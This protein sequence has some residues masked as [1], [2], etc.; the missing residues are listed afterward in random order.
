MRLAALLFAAM[1]LAQTPAPKS[2]T[3]EQLM[4][5]PFPSS[6]VASP[7]G[8][9]IAWV[10]NA[11]GVRNIWIAM[12]PDYA[13][14]KAIT[15]FKS[16]DGQEISSLAW[17]ADAGAIVFVRGTGPNRA[18]EIANA[19]SDPAGV[20]QAV[21]V[22]PSSGGEPR[23]LGEGSGPEVSKSGRVAWISKG[24]VWSAGAD[25]G[26][27]PEQLFK[28]RGTASSLRW[29][30]DGN[31]L[32]FVS[33]RGDHGF[34]GVYDVTAK[35]LRFLAAS[36]DSD[37][38]PAWSPDGKQIAFL[39]LPA[40]R[41]GSLF[42]P[43]RTGAPW[44][45]HIA[46]VSSGE[47]RQMFTAEA[48]RGSVFHAMTAPNQVLWAS[49]GH[50]VFP[51][52]R[53]GW[54][55]LYAVSVT[56][57]TAGPR[58]LTFGDF[59]VE[60]ARLTADGR[61]VL[62]SSNSDDIDR[63]H[64][65]RVPA[66]G[67]AVTPVTSGKG[68]EWS[69]VMTSDGKAVAFLRSDAR[70]P[71]R[72][73]VM[74]AF[75]SPRDLMPLE[76]PADAL[77]EPQPVVITAADGMKIRCQLFASSTTANEKRPA[78]LF[79]HGGSRRQMLLG[80]HYMPY[81]HATYAMNQWLASKGYIVLSVNYRSGT[82]YG[83]DFREATNFG[84]TGAAE[85]NDVMGAGLYLQSRADVDSARIGL[86]G[87]SYGGYLT[88][89]GLARASNL[90]AAGVDIHGVHDWNVVLRNFNPGYNALANP[91]AAKLAFESSP[92]AS[93]KTWKSPVLLI[94]GDDDRNVPFSESVTM[95]AALRK[96]GVEFEQLIFP[97][98]IH[99]FLRH[100]RWLEVFRAAGDFLDRQLK[101]S[102]K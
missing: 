56:G 101:A 75:G 22:V 14:P 64:L 93:V 21:W 62:F 83:L 31:Q 6:L 51:W 49:S 69:P 63:R 17:T 2:L 52:E 25:A 15:A 11:A 10:Q 78:V 44:S 5:A 32:A 80:W 68:I 48:G 41:D 13:T 39:R 79:F 99:G 53:D 4:G 94:H 9:H 100:S 28:M 46:D 29:S 30:P 86:W 26:G 59:E 1:A 71:A 58:L 55:H 43:V 73:A 45:I 66:A 74:A 34:V 97:D 3:I 50:I 98:E 84:A 95:A 89:L 102:K 54:L 88:A 7:T 33:E 12:A 36:V 92:M 24:Q 67:G 57:G 82:G 38:E 42:A 91:E 76:F 18:G 60:E 96:Q 8:G 72:A 70:L 87:G 35:S 90:F 16:D 85:F 77:V 40:A 19:M 61:E 23:R 37:S 47:T 81:Y 27:K 65:F 20:E